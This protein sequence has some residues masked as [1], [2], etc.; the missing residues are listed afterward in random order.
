MSAS[1]EAK[2]EAKLA[3]LRQLLER[4]RA[5][6]RH[7]QPQLAPQL[8]TIRKLQVKAL[9]DAHAK[10]CRDPRYTAH[11][12]FYLDELHSGLRLDRLAADGDKLLRLLARLDRSFEA[13]RG[14]FEFSVRAQELDDALALILSKSDIDIVE[15]MRNA[16]QGTARREHAQQLAPLG[17]G[18]A[19]YAHSRLAWAA[20][21]FGLMRM[22][23]GP[24]A[25]LSGT[26]QRGFGA[27]RELPDV[28]AAFQRLITNNLA[29]VDSLYKKG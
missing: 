7:S 11:F 27:L 24:F 19:K 20:F 1:S 26:L 28:E 14:S 18:L 25:P 13:V 10:D 16:D 22:R 8:A 2:L 5:L 6:P 17:P 29:A 12:E 23:S 3:Q 21:K 4:Y 15:L 9:R